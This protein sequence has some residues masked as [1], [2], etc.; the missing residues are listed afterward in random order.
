MGAFGLEDWEDIDDGD[1]P[2]LLV[3]NGA[4]RAVSMKFAYESLYAIAPLTQDDRDLFDALG[5]TNFEEILNHLRTASLVCDQLG[6]AS[7]DVDDRYD[8]IRDALINAVQARH[9]G[10]SDADTGDRLLNIRNALLDYDA[11][12]TTNYDLLIYWAMMNAGTPPGAGFG[13]LFWNADYA[14]DSFDTEP[15]RNKTLVYWLHGGLHLYRTPAGETKKR[16]NTGASLLTTFAA[17]NGV[18]LFVSEGTWQQKRRAIRRSDYLEHVYTAFA[19]SEGPLVVFGQA[20]GDPDRHLVEAVRRDPAREI[21]Y[22]IYAASQ[23]SA[24]LQRAQ[25]ENH[26]AQASIAF[27]DSTT[28]P[29][30]DPALA[31]P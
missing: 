14:F 12:F 2:T 31:V 6:H 19:Q 30:G 28:H 16:T 25:I 8:S 13:D 22:G 21:A 24:N 17:G 5:T 23:Q 4:S 20:F 15:F 26:F 10:W 27:F 9:V 3:G 18:P 1:W 29:L 7:T 11:V